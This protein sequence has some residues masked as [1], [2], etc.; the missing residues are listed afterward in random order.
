MEIVAL[1][2]IGAL[3]WF[4]IDTLSA[5]EV[6]LREGR[7]ACDADGLQLLDDTVAVSKLRLARN[8]EGQ[9]R[10]KRT[11]DFEFSD[12]GNNRRRGTLALVGKELTMIYTVPRIVLDMPT[13][14]H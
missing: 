6:A 14:L 10:I 4:W 2:L 13:T 8:D 12:T 9:L 5:R 7:R 11:Y 3:G 1:I